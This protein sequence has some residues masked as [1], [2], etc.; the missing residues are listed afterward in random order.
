TR[1]HQAGGSPRRHDVQQAT[2][3]ASASRGGASISREGRLAS[4]EERPEVRQPLISRG[5]REMLPPQLSH[6]KAVRVEASVGTSTAGG[7]TYGLP[8]SPSSSGL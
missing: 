7:S 6:P 1:K 3:Q 4:Q 5:G 2:A 8:A